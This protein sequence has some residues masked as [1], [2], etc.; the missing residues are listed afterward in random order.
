M[1][2]FTVAQRLMAII[3]VAQRLMAIIIWGDRKG[4][5]LQCTQ[6]KNL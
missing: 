6:N 2:I 5:T 4:R 1:A 3:T